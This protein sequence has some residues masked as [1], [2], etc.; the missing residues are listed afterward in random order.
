MIAEELGCIEKPYSFKNGFS[1]R[2]Y[3]LKK[4]TWCDQEMFN[5]TWGKVIMISGLPGTGKDTWISENYP[6]L[7]MVSL[8]EIRKQLKI[9]PT[10]NQG[11]AIATAQGMAKGY[12]RNKQPFVW[13][14]TD[15]TQATR[16]KWVSLFEQYGAAVEVVFLETEW[17]EQMRR[18]ENRTASVPLNKIEDMLSKLEI[19]QPFESEKVR[20]EIT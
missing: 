9:L 12:L 16:T 14:A 3:F 7:P 17:E 2:A 8:D 1:Q 5:D 19:P 13:N 15:I 10:D 6:D 4:T 11:K 20:W 18:N